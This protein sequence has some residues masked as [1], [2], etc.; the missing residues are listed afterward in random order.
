MIGGGAILL[1]G[2]YVGAGS[3]VGTGPMETEGQ[4]IPPRSLVLG[5]PGRVV[6]SPDDVDLA[7]ARMAAPHNVTLGPAHKGRDWS[8]EQACGQT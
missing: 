1:N 8:K 7:L 4:R 6:P 5:I 2:R 3:I